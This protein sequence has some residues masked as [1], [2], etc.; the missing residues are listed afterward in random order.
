M[1]LMQ[2]TCKSCEGGVQ[3]L[4]SDNIGPYLDELGDAWQVI[5]DERLVRTFSFTTFADA[6]EFVNQVARLA[7]SE[8]HHPDIEIH[9]SR[10]LIELSTHAIGGLSENDFILAAKINA[11]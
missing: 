1:N 8:G 2:K 11:L 9:Y 3:P 5:D 6:M 4:L 7:E 10:V